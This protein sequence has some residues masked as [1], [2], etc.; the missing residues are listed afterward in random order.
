LHGSPAEAASLSNGYLIYAFGNITHETSCGSDPIVLISN[1]VQSSK[2]NEIE[3][4]Y[5]KNTQDIMNRTSITPKEWNGR[6]RLF[7][8]F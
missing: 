1:M 4:K 8:T 2:G 3:V 5:K 6:G 7:Y